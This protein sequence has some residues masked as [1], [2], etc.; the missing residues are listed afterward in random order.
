MKKYQKKK[1]SWLSWFMVTRVQDKTQVLN[2][3]SVLI[4]FFV[5]LNQVTGPPQCLL[6]NFIKAWIGSHHK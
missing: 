5:L 4:S 6:S 1:D 3:T 2:N